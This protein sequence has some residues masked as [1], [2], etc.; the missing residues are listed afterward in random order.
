VS[1]HKK[2]PRFH[3]SNSTIPRLIWAPR[4]FA[5]KGEGSSIGRFSLLGTWDLRD[6]FKVEQ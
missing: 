1:R 5:W 3:S 4:D 2:N 6:N